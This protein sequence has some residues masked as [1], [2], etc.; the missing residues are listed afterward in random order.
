MIG[1]SSTPTIISLPALFVTINGISNPILPHLCRLPQFESSNLP[2][3][4]TRGS[5]CECL[6]TL[7][8]S[9]QAHETFCLS[10]L[11]SSVELTSQILVETEH[12]PLPPP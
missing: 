2:H 9:R 6:L 4:A 11:C 1:R 3:G 7:Q 10:V 8:P 5:A 12:A